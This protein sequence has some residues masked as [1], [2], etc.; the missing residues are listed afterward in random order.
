MRPA[1]TGLLAYLLACT[2]L[3]AV[4][5][6]AP[7]AIVG[8]W[9]TQGGDAVIEIAAT[10]ATGKAST[11]TRYQG[12]LAWLRERR[13]PADDPQGMAD[14]PVADRHN[15]NPALRERPLLGLTLLTGLHYRT[16]EDDDAQWV[17]GRIYDTENGKHYDCIVW[18]VDDDHLKLRGYV[19]I[20]LLG[21][22]TTWTR[23]PDP[24]V[25]PPM[26]G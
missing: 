1:L 9:Q 24:A 21:R 25:Q 2:P 26:E 15:P 14:Q 4:A 8:F 22:T 3:L 23:V 19:G 7:D 5:Q 12:Q 18:L 20:E 10:D 6:A 11:S 13:Y 16:R 17:D